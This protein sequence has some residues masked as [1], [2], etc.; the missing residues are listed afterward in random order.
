MAQR[1]KELEAKPDNLNL[2]L[3]SH[4]MEVEP[5]PKSYPLTFTYAHGAYAHMRNFKQTNKT[6]P[7]RSGRVKKAHGKAGGQGAVKLEPGQA[8]ITVAFFCFRSIASSRPH[9]HTVV[10]QAEEGAVPR[11]RTEWDRRRA[12][13][14][15]QQIQQTQ[16]FYL[17]SSMCSRS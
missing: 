10:C 12:G 16:G 6:F 8:Q 4:L 14:K 5:T 7:A 1:V 3:R 11:N 15:C 13:D 2:V 17:R 9:G